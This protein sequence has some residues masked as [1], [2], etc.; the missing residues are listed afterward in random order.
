MSSNLLGGGLLGG[1]GGAPVQITRFFNGSVVEDADF[2][3]SSN[4]T[5]IT[6]S[7]QKTG[8][9]N[10]N[11]VF[12]GG[13]V[14][15]DTTPAATVELTAGTDTVPVLNHIFIPEDT[16]VLTKNTTGFPT[17]K[18]FVPI[19]T[20]LCQTAASAQTQGL[21]KAHAWDDHFVDP[22]DEGH[23]Q[24]I[25]SWIRRQHAT[26][27]SGIVL[28]LT[29]SGTGSVTVETTSGIVLQLHEHIMPAVGSGDDKLVK[30]D[31]VAAYAAVDNINDMLLD[32]QG[33]TLAN[34]YYNLVLWG[35]VSEDA[36]DSRL[37][38]NLPSGAYAT[39]GNAETD[40]SGFTDF[41]VPGDFRGAAFV[42]AK[43]L[44]RNQADTTW[45][46]VSTE[47]L[48]GQLPGGIIAGSGLAQI[49]GAYR[50]IQVFTA[51]GTYTKPAGLKRA[52][53]Q[54]VGPGGG[55]GGVSSTGTD[56]A[57]GGGC[58]GGF[59]EKTIEAGAIG[60]TESV[61]VGQGGAGGAAGAAGS[62]GSASTA[63]GAIV[64]ATAGSGGF[65]ASDA[66]AVDRGGQGNGSGGDFNLNGGPGPRGN[67]DGDGGNGGGSHLC[68][69]GGIGNKNAN[70]SDAVGNAYGVGGGGGGT[71]TTTGYTGGAGQDG[72]VIVW[73]YF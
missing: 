41:T 6:A 71:T 38:F 64:S 40:P 12:N 22:V 68:P 47:D 7:F 66:I 61:V 67:T 5:V 59:A 39:Q 13:L 10:L 3:V 51:D 62:S 72:I 16:R 11:L 33:V 70:G 34:R 55:G 29:G 48:R 14:V 56:S 21:Y 46:I 52:K 4:G 25:S 58:G 45:T 63:F 43:I 15:F 17:D 35:C 65:G 53:V 69:M 54:A 32:S 24:H 50:S 60:A 37:F 20:V 19:A 1:G 49:D 30:N 57:G 2:S 9:G 23:Q 31:S 42:I 28:T 44:V 8:G 27:F 26:W 73:E 18:Q 36:A